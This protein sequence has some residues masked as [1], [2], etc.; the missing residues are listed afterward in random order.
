MYIV[1][2]EYLRNAEEQEKL[3]VLAGRDNDSGGLCLIDGMRD[4]SW[5]CRRIDEAIEIFTRFCGKT[6]KKTWRI[7]LE[8]E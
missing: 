3:I 1:H 6:S 2:V 4:A 5:S 7:T 8:R